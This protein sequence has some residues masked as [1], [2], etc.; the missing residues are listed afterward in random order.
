MSRGHSSVEIQVALPAPTDHAVVIDLRDAVPT[1]I[2]ESHNHRALRPGAASPTQDARREQLD[3]LLTVLRDSSSA[4]HLVDAARESLVIMHMGLVEHI[5]RKFRDRGEPLEDLVQ[6]GMLALVKSST[7]FDAQRG[8]E[9]STYATA[10]VTGEIKRHFRDRTWALHVPRRMQELR[11]AVM[12]AADE[13]SHRD[14]RAPTDEDIATLLGVSVD[15]VR[16]G[17]ACARAYRAASLDAIVA[18]GIDDAAQFVSDD[19]DLELVEIRQ[20]VLPLLQR[21]PERERHILVLR[22]VHSWS[23]SAIAEHIGISQMHVSRLLTRSLE[24][25]RQWLVT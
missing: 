6:V 11:Q 1:Q 7:R 8:I 20:M 12:A 24:R 15:D 25:M 23:Q 13:L 5:A 4:E 9:F 2:P 16:E 17:R 21:L 18:D 19:D 14:G 10:T 3:A 22:F